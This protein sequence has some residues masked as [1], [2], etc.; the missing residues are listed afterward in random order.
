MPGLSYSLQILP[1]E[2]RCQGNKEEP[3]VGQ[4]RAG[5]GRG[6]EG[7]NRAGNQRGLGH[8][9]PQGMMA[10]ADAWDLGAGEL[11]R[12]PSV[13]FPPSP[14]SCSDRHLSHGKRAASVTSSL[15]EG[16]AQGMSNAGHW[17][18][19]RCLSGASTVVGSSGF[20][21]RISSEREGAG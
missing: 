1:Q 20:D 8:Q 14:S 13:L 9:T 5:E 16:V 6:G 10:E 4:G 2:S 18:G 12:T 19:S 11:N 17:R 3:E 7:R 21:I 15:N